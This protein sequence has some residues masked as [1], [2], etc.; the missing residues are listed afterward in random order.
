MI[1]KNSIY[2]FVVNVL[3]AI[4]RFPLSIICSCI[5]AA[6][7]IYN[8]HLSGNVANDVL[9]NNL[10]RLALEA[11]AGIPMFYAFH[12]FSEN[13][14]LDI[15]KRLGFVLLGF[16]L[17]GL[18]FYSIPNGN[19]HFDNNYT[20]RYLTLLASVHLIISFSLYY[21]QSQ[22]NSFWYYNEYLFVK[23]ITVMLFSLTFYL[24]II[25]AMW[26][27]EKLLDLDISNKYYY[28]VFLVVMI[29]INTIFYYSQLPQDSHEFESQKPYQNGLRLFVQYILIPI[30]VIYGAILIIYLIKLVI[31]GKVPSVDVNLPILIYSGLGMLTYLLAY[32]IRN[33]KYLTIT[34]FYKYFFFILLPLLTLFFKASITQIVKYGFTE[35]RYLSLAIGVWLGAVALYGILKKEINIILIPISLCLVLIFSTFGP[36]GMYSTSGYSQYRILRNTMQKNNLLL[37]GKVQSKQQLK[38]SLPKED[39]ERILSSIQYLYA[40]HQIERIEPLLLG[41]EYTRFKKMQQEGLTELNARNFLGFSDEGVWKNNQSMETFATLYTNNP[42]MYSHDYNIAPFQNLRQIEVFIN[43]EEPTPASEENFARSLLQ[44]NNLIL[45]DKQK[46]TVLVQDLSACA[47]VVENWK[48]KLQ[49]DSSIVNYALDKMSVTERE[50]LLPKDSLVI[51]TAKSK[52]FIDRIKYSLSSK[53]TKVVQLN[54]VIAY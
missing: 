3:E 21:N 1:W 46:D 16:A 20:I 33:G 47:A 22:I 8:N 6:L 42:G 10:L 32:P 19:Y 26:S 49:N 12:I 30:V 27:V 34:I 5:A 17:L 53:D 15:Y 7:L 52:I 4:T 2:K 37:N 39:A 38:S 54:G 31:Q 45:L 50:F 40:H 9:G 29:P 28:D 23:F 11:I 13:K 41:E 43:T 18:H 44:N 24:G 25:G 36:W 35:T 14:N 51:N 48:S